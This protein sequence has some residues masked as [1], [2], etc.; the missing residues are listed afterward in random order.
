[1]ILFMLGIF[2]LKKNIKKII[3]AFE[4]LINGKWKSFIVIHKI[5]IRNIYR[6]MLRL[7]KISTL[8]Q[9]KKKKVCL[10]YLKNKLLV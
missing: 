10:I 6:N 5:S 1:M 9:K 2:G 4:M 7:K 8:L 3:N